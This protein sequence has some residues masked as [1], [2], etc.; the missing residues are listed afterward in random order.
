MSTAMI[1][2]TT[3]NS[4]SVTPRRQLG[5]IAGI[6]ILHAVSFPI[7]D[8]GSQSVPIPNLDFANLAVAA[9]GCQ[10]PAVGAER[11]RPDRATMSTQRRDAFSGLDV[12]DEHRIHIRRGQML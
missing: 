11:N 8:P 12:P 9:A 3:S 4:M 6:C 2:I 1:A 10:I 7:P 5:S